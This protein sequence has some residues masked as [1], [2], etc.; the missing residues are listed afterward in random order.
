MPHLGTGYI[1]LFCS[2]NV[3]A[4]YATPR[5]WAHS[6]LCQHLLYVLPLL[7][8]MMEESDRAGMTVNC[9]NCSEPA[10]SV[11]LLRLDFKW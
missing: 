5:Y 10:S 2:C 8:Y 4:A 11:D 1:V 6:L 9:D 3:A 7:L